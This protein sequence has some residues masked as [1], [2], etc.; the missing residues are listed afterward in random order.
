MNK[1]VFFAVMLG[2][3]SSRGVFAEDAPVS[4]FSSEEMVVSATK[5][6]NSVAD[7]GGSSVTVITAE[8]IENSGK[9]TVEEVIKGAPGIDVAANG[10][11]GSNTSIYL[12]GADAKYTLVLID[13]VPA[14]DPADGTRAPNLSNLTVDNIERIEIVRGPASMLYGSGAMAGV[15]NIITKSGAAEPEYYVGAE[16]GSYGTWKLYGGARGKMGIVDYAL[17]VARLESAGFSSTDEHNACINPSDETFEDDGYENTTLSGN[18]GIQLNDAVTLK[19]VLRYTDAYSEYDGPGTDIDGNTQDSELFNARVAL[20]LDYS[21]LVSTVYYDANLQKRSYKA[22]GV[23]SSTYEGFLYDIGWQ[24]DYAVTDTNMLSVGLNSQHE[25]MEN[26]SFGSYASV[27]DKEVSSHALFIEDQW[28][29][30]GLKIV[31]GY[32]YEDHEKFGEK[33]TFRVAPS[34]TIGATVFKASYG[35]GFRAPSLYELYSQYGNEELS[36]ETSSGWDAGFEHKVFDNLKIGSTY[37]RTDFDNRIEFDLDSWIYAQVE[38]KTEMLGVESFIEW[39]PSDPIFLALS[40]TYT[41]TQDAQDEELLRRPKNK[42]ALSGSWKATS[43]LKINTNMQWVGSRRD[44]NAMDDDCEV[45]GKLESYFLI[46]AGASFKV[47][48]YVQLY[49]RIENL[50][51]EHYEEAWRYATPGRSAYAGMKVTF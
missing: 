15:I 41:Y 49:G 48:D 30:G 50:F 20:V 6:L 47:D 2:L 7:A 27:L 29:I 13:G 28:Q 4:Y 24:G 21:P 39:Q 1:K 22:D 25:S 35:T 18:F 11:L 42:V 26:E 19:T 43:K 46:N 31:G 34:Y 8:E 33:S 14:N 51:D 12:R 44:R 9:T 3:L 10:G 37:F 17:N 32:R 45:T 38:G 5:T 23:T 36:A 16:G 40:H